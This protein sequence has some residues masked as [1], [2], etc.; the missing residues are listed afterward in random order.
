MRDPPH[1]PHS[2]LHH[3]LTI[4]TAAPANAATTPRDMPGWHVEAVSSGLDG[5]PHAIK[6]TTRQATAIWAARR[7]W[8][9]CHRELGKLTAQSFQVMILSVAERPERSTTVIKLFVVS[10]YVV[11][12]HSIEPIVSR[13]Q[14]SACPL[15]LGSPRPSMCHS[16]PAL[17]GRQ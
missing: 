2:A 13:F 14:G 11:L 10:K 3:G 8:C 4:T 17:A 7:S 16:A 6:I 9:R 5:Q 15:V 1:R 12:T